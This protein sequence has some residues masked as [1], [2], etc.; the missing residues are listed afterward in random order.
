MKVTHKIKLRREF[1][2]A[3][4]DG[5]KTFE[6][7]NNDRGYQTGDYIKFIPVEDGNK[8]VHYISHPLSEKTFIIT[9]VLSGWS[10]PQDYVVFAIKD[11]SE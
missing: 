11:V 4:Y 10:I 9:Y 3:V 6:I 2:D 5:R 8:P 1:C 7:R